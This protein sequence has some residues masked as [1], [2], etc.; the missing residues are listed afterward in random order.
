MFFRI[1][2]VHL[3]KINLLVQISGEI[4]LLLRSDDSIQCQVPLKFSRSIL[5]GFI[6]IPRNITAHIY[7]LIF[8]KGAF[9][10]Y[11]KQFP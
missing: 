8:C 9:L 3:L 1:K 7:M 10:R 11:A 2:N 5:E 4:Y 6:W